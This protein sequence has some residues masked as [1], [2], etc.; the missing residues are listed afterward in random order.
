MTRLSAALAK[1]SAADRWLLVEAC[2]ALCAAQAILGFLSYRRLRRVLAGMSTASISSAGTSGAQRHSTERIRWA[3]SKARGRLPWTPSCL[4][5]ALA[6]ARMLERRE[7]A[8]VLCLGV[9]RDEAGRLEGHAWVRSG[10]L[11][12]TGESE[13]TQFTL[14]ASFGGPPES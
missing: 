11:I 8:R 12:V 13:M 10:D 4:A 1:M 7:L 9:G 6:A 2:V 3:V 5:A 14:V